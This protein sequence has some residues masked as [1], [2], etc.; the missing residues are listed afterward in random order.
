MKHTKLVDKDK[1]KERD[2]KGERNWRAGKYIVRHVTIADGGHRD[3][4]PPESIRDGFE[5]GYLRASLG[6]IDGTWK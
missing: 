1:L 6:K 3:Y 5:V 4:G 2:E